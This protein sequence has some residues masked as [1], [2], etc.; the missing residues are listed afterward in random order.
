MPFIVPSLK[1][2]SIWTME[3]P[4]SN[5]CQALNPLYKRPEGVIGQ[6]DIDSGGGQAK[7]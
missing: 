6:F 4:M 3:K 5:D 7:W 1:Y 2:R